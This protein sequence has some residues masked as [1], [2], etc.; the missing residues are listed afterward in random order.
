[1]VETSRQKQT[2]NLNHIQGTENKLEIGNEQKHS[3]KK[4]PMVKFDT[5]MRNKHIQRQ[6]GRRGRQ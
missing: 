4:N 1:M 3:N 5:N 6:Y 2:I